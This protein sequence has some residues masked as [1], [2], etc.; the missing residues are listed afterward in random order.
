MDESA[1]L[2][3]LLA[4]LKLGTHFQSRPEHRFRSSRSSHDI[5]EITPSDEED[6]ELHSYEYSPSE[7]EARQSAAMDRDYRHVNDLLP[8]MRTDYHHIPYR[9]VNNLL[10]AMRSNYHHIPIR[11]AWADVRG[12]TRGLHGYSHYPMSETNLLPT[13]R[14]SYEPDVD[15]PNEYYSDSSDADV[16]ELETV[17]QVPPADEDFLAFQRTLHVNG[18]LQTHRHPLRQQNGRRRNQ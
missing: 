17:P 13:R 6:D 9:H 4:Q 2:R 18:R 8:A 11:R 15:N 1:H 10:P 16:P 5:V 12:V 14:T 7:S 3:G